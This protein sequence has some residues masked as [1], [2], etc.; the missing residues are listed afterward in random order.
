MLL[1]RSSNMLIWWV[2]VLSCLYF[3]RTEEF[4]GGDVRNTF[5]HTSSEVTTWIGF[6]KDCMRCMKLFVLCCFVS[7][8]FFCTV[9]AN[10]PRHIQTIMLEAL[11]DCVSGACP[12]VAT[13]RRQNGCA[14]ATD[15]FRKCRW[16]EAL[17]FE[18]ACNLRC[19]LAPRDLP[20]PCL[21]CWESVLH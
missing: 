1:S 14:S 7:V 10:K 18:A 8:H 2:V 9:T 4:R 16:S 21:H 12:C 19:L 15:S 17:T 5:G 11:F 6:L 20:R 13:A 3:L